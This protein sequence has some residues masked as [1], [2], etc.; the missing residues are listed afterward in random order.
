VLKVPGG[1]RER[2]SVAAALTISPR[3]HRLGL[4]F[5]TYP[6]AFVN[7]E[8]AADFLRQVLDAQRSRGEA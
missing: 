6:K 4:Q 3:R 7:Q 5:R 8:R 2:V 1:H